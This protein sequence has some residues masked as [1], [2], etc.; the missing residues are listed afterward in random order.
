MSFGINGPS[1]IPAIQQSQRSTD[2]GAG[3]LGYFQREKK[4]KEDDEEAD[5]FESSEEKTDENFDDGDPLMDELDAIGTKIKN[6]W[7]KLKFSQNDEKKP[8]DD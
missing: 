2:G 5:I 4:K 6:F 8:E 7:M 3:N 1:N